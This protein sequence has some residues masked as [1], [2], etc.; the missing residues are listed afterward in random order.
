MAQIV[1]LKQWNE[2]P[3]FTNN[4]KMISKYTDLGSPDG[5]KSL[6]GIVLNISIN[7]PS[8]AVS[9]SLFNFI[10]SYRTGPDSAF[11]FMD[12]IHNYTLSS[13]DND[14]N[15][16]VLHIFT[17]PIK[18]ILNIQLKIAGQLVNDIGINDFGLVFRTYRDSNV[19]S[20][21]D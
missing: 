17:N 15:I 5:R 19:V 11:K 21:D 7:T 1:S 8:D 3:T 14:G 2:Q 4:F 16:E 10:I 18:N 13:Y 20:L 12:N 6:L 9:P